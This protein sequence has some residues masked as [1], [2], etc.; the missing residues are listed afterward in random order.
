[1]KWHSQDYL[2]IL[3]SLPT[4]Y[5]TRETYLPMTPSQRWIRIQNFKEDIPWPLLW[6]V[7]VDEGVSDERRIHIR[8]IVTRDQRVL[9]LRERVELAA[10]RA[11]VQ[12]VRAVHEAD[13]PGAAEPRAHLRLAHGAQQQSDQKQQDGVV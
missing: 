8:D 10:G 7:H 2:L 13:G 9:D 3:P 11:Q 6:V 1:M 5:T 12:G 4:I